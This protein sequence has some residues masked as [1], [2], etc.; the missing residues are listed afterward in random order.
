MPAQGAPHISEFKINRV[1]LDLKKRL[2]L[3]NLF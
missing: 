1:D 2:L 3:L